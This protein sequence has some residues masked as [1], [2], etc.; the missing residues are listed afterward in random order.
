MELTIFAK[1]SLKN[2]VYSESVFSV[3]KSL[4]VLVGTMIQAVDR[5]RMLT[6]ESIS[7]HYPIASRVSLSS[8][9]LDILVE[10]TDCM[11]NGLGPYCFLFFILFLKS[12]EIEIISNYYQWHQ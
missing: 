5:V 9:N 7:N 11:V 8:A 12:L 3:G 4:A 6:E 1:D 2:F 10:G